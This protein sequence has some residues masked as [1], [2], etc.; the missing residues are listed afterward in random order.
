MRTGDA[1]WE[2][3]RWTIIEAT[4]ASERTQQEAEEVKGV[5][6]VLQE[7]FSKMHAI[8]PGPRYDTSFPIQLNERKL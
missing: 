2:P 3:A 8:F 7:L 5:A 1:T 4:A 6:S